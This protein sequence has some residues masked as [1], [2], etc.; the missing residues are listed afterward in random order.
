MPGGAPLERSDDAIRII[1]FHVAPA[2]GAEVN[3]NRL[4][5]S[6]VVGISSDSIENQASPRES[7]AGR[8]VFVSVS[9]PAAFIEGRLAAAVNA[10]AGS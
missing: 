10:D 4:A 9:A 1:I 5:G 2:S 7:R 3:E 8:E 6:R